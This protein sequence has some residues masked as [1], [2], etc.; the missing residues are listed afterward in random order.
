MRTTLCLLIVL[1]VVCLGMVSGHKHNKGDRKHGHEHGCDHGGGHDQDDEGRDDDR[2]QGREHGRGHGRGHDQDDEGRDDNRG[3]GREHGRGHGRGHD[4]DDKGRDHDHGHGRGREH[5]HHHHEHGNNVNKS[6]IQG[7]SDF[8][9]RLYKQLVAL[10]ANQNEN[11]FFSPL[12]VS[13]ALAALSVG[14]KGQTHQQL[15]AGLGFNSS[16]WDQEQIGQVFQTI[17]RQLNQKTAV[18]LSVGSAIFLENTLKP[19][20]EF[21]ETL[22]RFYLT[23]GFPVDF[24]DTA[25]AIDTINTYV[26]DKTHGKIDK[27]VNDLDPAT[28][29]YLLSYMYFKGKWEI[30]FD[31]KNT[32]D[33]PFHINENTTVPVQ[34]MQLEDRFWAYEDRE[35]SA[36]ILKLHYNDSVSMMLVLPEKGLAKLEEV[37][38]QNHIAKW[39]RWMK[40]KQYQVYVPKLSITTKYSLT[41]VLRDMGMPE[42][43]TTSAN[44]SGISE[45]MRV[46][47]SEVVHQASLD[48]DEAGTTAVAVT[49][50]LDGSGYVNIGGIWRTDPWSGRL[51]ET[52]KRHISTEKG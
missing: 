21:L 30:P 11:V 23:E 44:F 1:A 19:L 4:H 52:K 35:L 42:I 17:L 36:S 2:G 16:Q 9:F 50:R 18:N 5:G 41:D 6:V 51:M 10:P 20:P 14:A 33:K 7:N 25:K 40:P 32:K 37:I 28:V 31:P 29:V 39:Q 49:A 8:A 34:M 3:Q 22:K 13:L 24:T 26:R 47:V 45:K 27:L 12:S 46:K 48:V 38:C 15:F 43:F